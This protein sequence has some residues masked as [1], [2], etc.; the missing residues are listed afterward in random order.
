MSKNK[1]NPKKIP[2]TQRDVDDAYELGV[3]K[4]VEAC[5]IMWTLSMYDCGADDEFVDRTSLKFSS[6]VESIHTDRINLYDVKRALED[7]HGI[8]FERMLKHFGYKS[9][10]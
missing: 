3:Y 8:V 4:G 7:E 10:F 6:N 5:A 1:T 2:R 9:K